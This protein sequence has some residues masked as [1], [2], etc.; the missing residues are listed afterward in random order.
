MSGPELL[1]LQDA[2]V[3]RDGREILRIENLAV[4]DGERIAILGPNGAGK[5]TLVGLL[6]GEAK[7]LW[8]PDAPIRFR[9]SR[10]WDLSEA[11]SYIGVVSHGMQETL[12]RRIT[13]RE[14]VVG[15]LFGA[16]GVPVHRSPAL[17]EWAAA[18]SALARLGVG[19]LSDRTMSTLSTGE[20]RRVVIA[21]ALVGE[22]SVIVLDEPT[23]GLDPG[24]AHSVR[25]AVGRLAEHGVT[26][27][28]VTHHV[29]DIP[30]S[31]DRVLLLAGG[32]V[33]ADGSPDSLLADKPLSELFGAPLVVRRRP[34]GMWRLG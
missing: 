25:S 3:V 1:T 26:M 22:P 17:A 21:R 32:R 13:A 9:G 6:T 33:V 23:A 18:D 34:G 16:V 8:A 29:E 31:V 2:R 27:L 28:L 12:E 19:H 10:L 20:A 30:A 7:P 24:A 11:R 4:R 15:G 14:A 5:S